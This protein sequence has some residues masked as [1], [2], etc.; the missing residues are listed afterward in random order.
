MLG[1][2][3]AIL[4]PA[5]FMLWLAAVLYRVV[6]FQFLSATAWVDYNGLEGYTVPWSTHYVG[7]A[8]MLT[9]SPILLV[10]MAGSFILFNIWYVALS[11]LAFPR[12]VF[13]WGMD[14][15][16]PKWFTDIDYRWA[17][18]VKNHILCFVLAEIG[19]ALYS[20]WQNPMTGLSIT[21]LEIVSVFGVTALA[22]ILFPYMKSAA[23]I[24]EA[25]PYKTWKF[26]GIPAVVWGGAVNVIYLGILF[27]FYVVMPGFEELTIGSLIMYAVIWVLG[28]AWYFYWKAR[29]KQVGVDVSMTY[30]EL[31]P[32]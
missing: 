19:I 20:F 6:G 7:L 5:L 2:L 3:F 28:I 32:D 23:N 27:Y 30:G 26:L 16:G 10:M 21:A 22:A 8:A 15:M 13:A 31:P 29:N 18:P 24:W 17:T 1:N 9:K 25:S 4:V 14:R 11:Y 12:I